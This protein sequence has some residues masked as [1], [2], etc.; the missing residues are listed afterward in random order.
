MKKDCKA[1][2]LMLTGNVIP[3][4]DPRARI[5]RVRPD[6]YTGGPTVDLSPEATDE[7]KV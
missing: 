1:A 5:F 3:P 7:G 4:S 2:G 6:V